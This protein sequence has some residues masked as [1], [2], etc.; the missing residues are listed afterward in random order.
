[1]MPVTS[2]ADMLLYVVADLIDGVIN[3]ENRSHPY[4]HTSQ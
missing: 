1:M 3:H 4:F 2:T